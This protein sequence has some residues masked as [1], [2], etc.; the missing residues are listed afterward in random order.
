MIIRK[1]PP[2]TLGLDEPIRQHGTHK[3]PVTRRDF[4]SQGFV[5]G[6][7][8]VS[9]G[10]ILSLF[11]NPREAYA[12]LSPDLD[13]LKPG[14]GINQLG[15]GKIPFICI[16]L[17]GGANMA[18]SNVLGGQQGG[19]LDFISTAGYAKQGLPGDMTPPSPNAQRVQN[20]HIEDRLGLLFHSDSAFARGI[21]ERVQ[22]ANA[23]NINGAVI[24]AW[25]T[26][27]SVISAVATATGRMLALMTA[28]R[29]RMRKPYNSEI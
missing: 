26:L 3:R 9:A 22:P 8:T 12:A 15:A 11:A 4:I 23:L 13:A 6:A 24:P 10:G 20:N 25:R 1:P 14:C 27:R 21:L 7:A 2:R 29:V 28:V 19:Q 5:T 17:A 16:D 18:G